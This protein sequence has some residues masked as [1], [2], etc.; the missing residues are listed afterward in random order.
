MQ[1]DKT[2]HEYLTP[3]KVDEILK[4]IK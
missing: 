4:G 1:V 2:Y 3:A